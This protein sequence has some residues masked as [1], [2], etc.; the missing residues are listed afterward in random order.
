MKIIT[1]ECE[2][3][4]EMMIYADRITPEDNYEFK[5]IVKDGLSIIEIFL[6]NNKEVHIITSKE[7]IYGEKCT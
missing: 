7:N 6:Y 5:I 4:D 3:F 2:N 1:K